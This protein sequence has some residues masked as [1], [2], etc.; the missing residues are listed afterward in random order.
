MARQYDIIS[1]GSA[2]RDIFILNKDLKYPVKAVDP[3]DANVIGNKIAVR[4][5]YF[6]I[7]GGGSNT[8]ATLA[9]MGLQV[10]LFSIVSNDLAGKEVLKVMKRFKV[11]TKLI[12]IDK[13]EETGYSVIFI[14]KFHR[15][16]VHLFFVLGYRVRIQ[17]PINLV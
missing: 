1:I 17:A 13:T 16:L 4:D 5:M 15:F 11:D 12:K 7:G 6:D 9:N 14:N 3:F 2:V 10:G 8:A